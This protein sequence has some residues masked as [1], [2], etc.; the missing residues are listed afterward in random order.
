MIGIDSH[1][2]SEG[3]IKKR[4]FFENKT[5]T[6]IKYWYVG[7]AVFYMGFR[8]FVLLQIPLRLYI[9]RVSV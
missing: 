7:P 3:A 4:F 1:I 2:K 9:F 8:V 6:K 5:T